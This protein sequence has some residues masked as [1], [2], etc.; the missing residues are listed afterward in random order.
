MSD[1]RGLDKY[2]NDLG[3]IEEADSRFIFNNLY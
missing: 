3:L 1:I 2:E